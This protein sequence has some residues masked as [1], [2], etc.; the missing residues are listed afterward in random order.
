L[1]ERLIGA[2]APVAGEHAGVLF[3]HR[4]CDGEP[5]ARVGFVSDAVVRHPAE[6]R[7]AGAVAFVQMIRV[8][9]EHPEHGERVL[10]L[11]FLERALGEGG[12]GGSQS[13][14][15]VAWAKPHRSR[16]EPSSRWTAREITSGRTAT[17]TKWWTDSALRVPGSLSRSGYKGAPPPPEMT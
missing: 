2:R 12:G 6:V 8:V 9:L 14:P 1:G 15:A 10:V 7:V 11:V 5:V 13:Q 4:L 17:S 3:V 16:S